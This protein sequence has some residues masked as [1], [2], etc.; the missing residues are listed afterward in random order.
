M[1][2]RATTQNLL[3]RRSNACF[4]TTQT[5]RSVLDGAL[6]AK[7]GRS[8]KVSADKCLRMRDLIADDVGVSGGA[9][10]ATLLWLVASRLG[11]VGQQ[12]SA[13]GTH[14]G[15]VLC[16]CAAVDAAVARS[17]V[18]RLEEVRACLCRRSLLISDSTWYVRWR[19]R[20]VLRVRGSLRSA[21][22][23]GYPLLRWREEVH[24]G[25]AGI[26]ASEQTSSL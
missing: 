15:T 24:G 9:G 20:R 3:L 11:Q 7:S 4:T 16:L 21:H 19:T 5:L 8:H 26:A 17:P 12:A 1:Y 13:I 2:Q 18:L 22:A 14:A 25:G 10:S 6:H 23:Q